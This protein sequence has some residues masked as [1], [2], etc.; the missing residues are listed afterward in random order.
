MWLLTHCP[1]F[2]S[3]PVGS[4]CCYPCLTSSSLTPYVSISSLVPHSKQRSNRLIWTQVRTWVLS[5][6][7]ACYFSTTGCGSNLITPSL[8]RWLKSFTPPLLAAIWV[9]HRPSIGYRWVSIGPTCTK[10]SNNLFANVPL[11]NRLNMKPRNPSACS[12][13]YPY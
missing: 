2:P 8:F 6:A 4:V 12:N 13:H 5:F 1:E 9:S 7:M 11:A 3:T 10:M